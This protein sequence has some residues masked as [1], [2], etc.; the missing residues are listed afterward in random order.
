MEKSPGSAASHDRERV[1][2]LH[3][4]ARHWTTIIKRNRRSIAFRP[5]K[6][7]DRDLSRLFSPIHGHRQSSRLLH[8]SGGTAPTLGSWLRGGRA[9]T[10][11]A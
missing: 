8:S 10:T 1:D 5:P 9:R 6:T 4:L 11:Y 2:P 3:E 7:Y